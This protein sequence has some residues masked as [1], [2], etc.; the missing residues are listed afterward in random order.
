MTAQP[1]MV[2]C[3]R[4]AARLSLAGCQRQWKAAQ[5]RIPASWESIAHCRACPIGAV[6]SG[7]TVAAA[8]AQAA[9]A[10]LQTICPRCEK[11]SERLIKN[12]LC[13][14]CYN[15]DLEAKKGINAK[16]GRPTICDAIHAEAVAVTAAGGGD[17]AIRIVG[18]V[19]T[20]AEAIAILA[21]RGFSVFGRAPMPRPVGWQMELPV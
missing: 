4:M 12:H 16:G 15:R 5:E 17:G 14:S 3:S 8:S 20:R 6:R 1:E 13:I 2:E 21:R 19:T 11:P 18:R 7:A 10:A 9:T